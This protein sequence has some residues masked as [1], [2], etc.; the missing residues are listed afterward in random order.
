MRAQKS[1]Y[2]SYDD[3]FRR[4]ALSLLERT[5][6]SLKAV[7]EDLGVPHSTL[8]AWYTLDMAKRGKKS[9]TAPRRAAPVSAVLRQ[10]TETPEEKIARLEHEL[11]ALRRKN[12]ELEMDRAI[13]KKA[14]AFFAKESE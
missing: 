1:S 6:R 12:E 13:L 3:A 5:G 2:R 8:Q 14:A 7:S 10:A 4:D 9:K 11:A